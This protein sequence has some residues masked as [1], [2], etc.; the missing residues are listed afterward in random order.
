MGDEGVIRFATLFIKIVKNPMFTET[1]LSMDKIETTHMLMLTS[2]VLKSMIN[3]TFLGAPGIKEVMNDS[4]LFRDSML[5]GLDTICNMDDAL[6]NDL[7]RRSARLM[8]VFIMKNKHGN[9]NYNEEDD[10]DFNQ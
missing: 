7:C 6:L 5:S 1:M 3:S 4:V 8:L 9:T 2:P 10:N